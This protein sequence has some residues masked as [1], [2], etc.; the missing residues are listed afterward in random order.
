MSNNILIYAK[1]YMTT[2]V[3]FLNRCI[4]G[5]DKNSF[6]ND[7]DLRP[8]LGTQLFAQRFKKYYSKYDGVMQGLP[9][10][11][12]GSN[13]DVERLIEEEWNEI[14]SYNNTNVMSRHINIHYYLQELL[15]RV[16]LHIQQ[17]YTHN[18]FAVLS[19]KLQKLSS[20]DA[21]KKYAFISFNQDTILEHF[22]CQYFD[23][24]ITSLN[25]YTQVNDNPFC[26]FKPHGSWNWGWR[27]PSLEDKTMTTPQWLFKNKFNYYTLYYELLGNLDEM[28]DW[29]NWGAQMG[30]NEYNLSKLSIDK[31]K[32]S[33]ISKNN[34]NEHYPA[35]LLPYRDKDEFMMPP[36]HHQNLINYLGNV[37]TL[38]VIGW[39]GNEAAFNRLLFKQGINI[40]KVIIVDPQPTVVEENLRPLFKTNSPIKILY[41]DFE[42]FIFNG[43]EKE[44]GE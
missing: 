29:N 31:S 9:I 21:N 11:Q 17:S 33:L 32:V 36:S 37:K 20:R 2:V 44:L 16:S 14:N 41:K 42:D 15:Q 23:I 27:F 34:L 35:I 38:I 22:L 30:L 10:L 40:T 18:L 5:E 12:S 6:E 19:D 24:E 7:D 1:L 8:P 43:L 28:V 26:I 25:D 39:K 3:L 4:T 13:P